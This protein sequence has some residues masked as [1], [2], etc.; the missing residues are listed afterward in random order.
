[1]K[2]VIGY[3]PKPQM[4]H[5]QGVQQTPSVK[6]LCEPE[7]SAQSSYDPFRSS[8]P[9]SSSSENSVVFIRSES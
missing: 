8:P 3:L 9:V 1:M 5:H 7:A 2:D 4:K 6:E